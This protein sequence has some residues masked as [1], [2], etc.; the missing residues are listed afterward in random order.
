MKNL[1]AHPRFFYDCSAL[2]KKTCSFSIINIWK[3]TAKVHGIKLKYRIYHLS[4][5][6]DFLDVARGE[7]K[8][9]SRA[10]RF[11]D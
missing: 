6:S 1:V 2:R 4:H 7:K 3:R 10:E 8:E 5:V 11:T 9:D